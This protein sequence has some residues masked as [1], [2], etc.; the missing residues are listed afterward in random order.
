MSSSCKPLRLW[1][2][3]PSSNT[4]LE[5]LTSAIISQLSP[6]VSVHYSRF[7]ILKISLEPSILAQFDINGPILAAARLLADA[8]VDVIGWSGTREDG[9]DLRRTKD[10]AGR[11]PRIPATTST[12]AL[13]RALEI[14][15]IKK[16]AF[17]TPYLDDVQAQ[18]IET[19]SEAGYEVV[20]E[21]H[22]KLS[23]M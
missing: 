13:K 1:I 10:Y 12:M 5:P 19:Y 9:W 3:V 17:V 22:L 20:S 7:P 2:L 23:T 21:G 4:A 11:I 6:S 16:I 15:K 8:D 18:I 14:F